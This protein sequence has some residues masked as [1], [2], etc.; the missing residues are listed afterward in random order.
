MPQE[1]CQ[2][3]QS[4]F[5]NAE[6]QQGDVPHDEC[7]TISYKVR[8]NHSQ[9][10]SLSLLFHYS[11]ASPFLCLAFAGPNVQ[12]CRGLLSPRQHPTAVL[13]HK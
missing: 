8:C 12:V 7:F 4:F 2:R 1:L 13:H 9:G 6:A 11:K 10:T 3:L 5:S